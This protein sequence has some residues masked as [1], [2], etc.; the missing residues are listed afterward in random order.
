MKKT[1]KESIDSKITN[2]KLSGFITKEK[3][4]KKPNYYSGDYIN[5]NFEDLTL[6]EIKGIY[7]KGLNIKI[8]SANTYVAHET[9]E[10][11][12]K[13]SVYLKL[14][15]QE[16]SRRAITIKLGDL[17]VKENDC[18]SRILFT[19]HRSEFIK[20]CSAIKQM[21]ITEINDFV[22]G[23]I[24]ICDNISWGFYLEDDIKCCKLNLFG[25]EYTLK[26]FASFLKEIKEE[27]SVIKEAILEATN[28]LR[29]SKGLPAETEFDKS[30]KIYDN[31]IHTFNS[32]TDYCQADLVRRVSGY[33]TAFEGSYEWF[34]DEAV[35]ITTN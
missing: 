35:N 27:Q 25:K 28:K 14:S 1:I 32:Y 9:N 33:V 21:K 29:L 18:I 17:I 31:I 3:E 13:G 12:D 22:K 15:L 7:P 26:P 19:D 24:N 23:L 4:G 16:T 6:E 30:I 2:I 11:E 10:H 8:Q 20:K 34:C 5:E